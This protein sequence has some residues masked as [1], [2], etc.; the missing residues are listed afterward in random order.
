[1]QGHAWEAVWLRLEWRLAV[2]KL[3]VKAACIDPPA[4][5]PR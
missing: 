4:P 1:M 5:L 2:G 3:F